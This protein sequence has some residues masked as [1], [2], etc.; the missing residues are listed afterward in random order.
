MAVHHHRS[1]SGALV[2]A[3]AG[4]AALVLASPALATFPAPNGR[5][6][7]SS[8]A[9]EGVQIYTV[10]RRGHDL[11]QITHVS[12]D[13]IHPDWSPDGRQIV[14]ELD[15]EDAASVAFVDAS[16]GAPVVLP[17]VPGGFEAVAGHSYV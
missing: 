10:G 13:A 2:A 8:E 5:I 9:A 1:R 7:F 6:T 17:P 15:T 16:G 12:G 11:R 14:F 4:V 3:L